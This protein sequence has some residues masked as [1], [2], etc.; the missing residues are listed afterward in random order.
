MIQG[1]YANYTLILIFSTV[2]IQGGV[3]F[4]GTLVFPDDQYVGIAGG[5]HVH[6]G[7]TCED[8]L[9]VYFHFCPWKGADANDD[10]NCVL[11]DCGP[12]SC[13]A[14]ELPTTD[15]WDTLYTPEAG[16][17]GKAIAEFSALITGEVGSD[18]NKVFSVDGGNNSPETFE[19]VGHAVVIHLPIGDGSGARIGCGILKL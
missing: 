18:S 1:L 11:P 6:A 12:Y 8:A 14:G 13:Y 17:D 19:T 7:T 9:K 16:P 4:S 2:I 5:V 15:P 3:I 10:P